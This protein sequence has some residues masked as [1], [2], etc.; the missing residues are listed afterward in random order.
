MKRFVLVFL[1]GCGG[2]GFIPADLIA[3]FPD[4]S[5]SAS[6]VGMGDSSSP[7][8]GGQEE[9]IAAE[10]TPVLDSSLPDVSADH[11]MVDTWAP[12]TAPPLDTCSPPTKVTCLSDTDCQ[13]GTTCGGTWCCDVATRGCYEGASQSPCP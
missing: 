13:G 3:P 10:E 2:P 8:D 5:Q 1:L 7:A 4:A 9:P 12:D 6:E 11:E